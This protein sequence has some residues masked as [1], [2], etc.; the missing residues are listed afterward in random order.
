E[1]A[2]VPGMNAK[3]LARLQVLDNQFS[4]QLDPGRS[5]AAD[6]LQHEA[7]SSKNSRA[8]GLLETDAN[9]D[10]RHGTQKA[11]A[12]N[13]VFAAGADLDGNDMPGE[14]CGEGQFT[15]GAHGAIF[16]HEKC[17][18]SH[19]ALERAQNAATTA[20]LG[21]RSHLNRAAHPGKLA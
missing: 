13:H 12:V 4:G 5:L 20:Q 8:Q 2:D 19:N 9:L 1:G 15:R 11:V 14:F 7:A 17:S 10:I 3:R 6:T 18:P 16:G 21:V